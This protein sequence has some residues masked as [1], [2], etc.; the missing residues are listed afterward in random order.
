M[1]CKI[2]RLEVTQSGYLKPEE[3]TSLRDRLSN[4]LYPLCAHSD[5]R[6]RD[7]M[8]LLL[9]KTPLFLHSFWL[10]SDKKDG[11]QL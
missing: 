8:S 9:K 10:F 2:F 3:R 6:H 4:V 5:Y 1:W 7:A 11:K